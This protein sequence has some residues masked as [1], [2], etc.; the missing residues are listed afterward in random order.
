MINNDEIM[1][2]VQ[3]ESEP[4]ND[5]TDKSENTNNENSNCPSNADVFSALHAAIEWYEQSEYC[6]IQL[7]LLKIIKNLAVKKRRCTMIQR[8]ISD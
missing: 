1:T 5:E 3:E 7:L 4:V 2:S 8:K 6:H